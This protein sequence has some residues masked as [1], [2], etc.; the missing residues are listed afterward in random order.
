MAHPARRV[1]GRVLTVNGG[2]HDPAD[3]RQCPRFD[4]RV[5]LVQADQMGHQSRT[6][7]ELLEAGHRVPQ[8]VLV[9]VRLLVIVFPAHMGVFQQLGHRW[10]RIHAV[11]AGE[12]RR[13]VVDQPARPRRHR[14]KVVRLTRPGHRGEEGIAERI[15]ARVLPIIGNFMPVVI[16]KRIMHPFGGRT[17]GGLSKVL[18]RQLPRRDRL[19]LRAL[20]RHGPQQIRHLDRSNLPVAVA[21]VLMQ[22]GRGLG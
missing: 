12:V 1:G 16:R 21:V 8:A 7:L 22:P 14:V 6:L 13:R 11:L 9:R 18:R 19:A 20:G 2:R 4:V 17:S 15:P 3:F 5:E 10:E